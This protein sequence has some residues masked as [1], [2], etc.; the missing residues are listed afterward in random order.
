MSVKPEQACGRFA[1]R[2]GMTEARMRWRDAEPLTEI[3]GEFSAVLA[4]VDALRAA[5]EDVLSRVTAEDFAE[6][7][8]RTH[9]R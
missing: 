3:N 9:G 7:R 6:S 4:S 5:W 1:Y 2:Y 8:R